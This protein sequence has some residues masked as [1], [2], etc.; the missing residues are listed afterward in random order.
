MDTRKRMKSGQLY[1]CTDEE[2]MKEQVNCLELLYDFNHT[3]PSEAQK[4][5]EILSRL[6]AEK[7]EDVYIEPPLHANWGRN[8]H[9]GSHFY[10]NFNLTLV[11]DTDVYI[12]DH[13]MIGPNVTI[14]TGT[15]PI[16]PELRKKVAQ[17]NLPVWIGDNVWIGA[18]SIILPGV[19]IG[20][21]SVI[22][23]GSIVTRDIPDNVVAIGSPCR[24]LRPIT[25]RDLEYYDKDK[26]I[27]V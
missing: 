1:F 16:S 11:D 27:D 19:H 23:A 3:R 14:D 13:V 21:N 24:V 15:H 12:G 10:A 4:R 6:L 18:G 20:E 5:D 9:I 17:Y 25:S 7:G 26:L 8:T 2:V 22:G